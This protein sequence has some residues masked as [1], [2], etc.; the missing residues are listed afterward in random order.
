LNK[1]NFNNLTDPIAVI[2]AGLKIMLSESRTRILLILFFGLCL[3]SIEILLPL[4]LVKLFGTKSGENINFL[5]F[6]FD[7]SFLFIFMISICLSKPIFSKIYSNQISSFSYSLNNRI[8]GKYFSKVFN[9]FEFSAVGLEDKATQTL[10]YIYT[11]SKDF[12]NFFIFPIFTV[13]LELIILLL[14]L[15]SLFYINLK[16]TILISLLILV[17]VFPL[18]FFYSR[19]FRS[20]GE[21]KSSLEL[22][23]IGFIKGILPIRLL[24]NDIK[25]INFYNTSFNKKL[26]DL[27]Q[28]GETQYSSTFYLR[29]WV[30]SILILVYV[31]VIYFVANSENLE[32]SLLF[33]SVGF[34]LLR[35]AASVNRLIGA[36]GNFS[37]ASESIKFIS[38]LFYKKQLKLA[39][40]KKS[41]KKYK[42]KSINFNN[43]SYR[44]ENNKLILNNVTFHIENG[45][46]I[47][48]WG[49]SGSGKTT[50]LGLIMGAIEQSN[51]SINI[52]LSPA[53]LDSMVDFRSFVGYV[54]K[55]VN[56]LVDSVINNI[57]L[58]KIP[59]RSDY[60]YAFKLLAKVGLDR[61]F[62]ALEDL[63]KIINKNIFFSAGE[64]Q[65]FSIARSLF[66]GKKVLFLDEPTANLDIKNEIKI[67]DLLLS[68]KNLTI[69]VASHSKVLKSKFSKIIYV[70]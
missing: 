1:I 13:L 66:M 8:C 53:S 19:F 18:T 40:S 38:N 61:K 41:T 70:R 68:E 67:I 33:L 11:I 14:C 25:Q 27:S 30:E 5:N 31:V 45:D 28:I 15:I 3:T 4:S 24:L 58:G 62:V 56:F 50:L 39:L 51:G 7:K 57:A 42:F 59:T 26:S 60:Y 44:A 10:N 34:F 43:V 48:I 64:A 16:I 17:T 22:D 49:P 35:C 23:L 12:L 37:Y 20:L 6:T 47:C 36:L 63:D 29:S 52:N 32:L 69:I 46:K 55:E 9:E 2:S 54:P 65:R 21:K